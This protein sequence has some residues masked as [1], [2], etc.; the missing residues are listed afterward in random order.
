MNLNQE[1]KD[2][3]NI[4]GRFL[5]LDILTFSIS[6]DLQKIVRGKWWSNVNLLMKKFIMKNSLILKFKEKLRLKVK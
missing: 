2:R 6:L 4:K 3:I 1:K 5:T